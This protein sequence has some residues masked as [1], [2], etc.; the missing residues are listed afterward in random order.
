MAD[1]IGLIRG[2]PKVIDRFGLLAS[3]VVTASQP[4][5]ALLG[6]VHA[7]TLRLTP[8]LLPGGTPRARAAC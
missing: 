7:F 5:S 4:V 6:R 3:I 8:F 1:R 2:D